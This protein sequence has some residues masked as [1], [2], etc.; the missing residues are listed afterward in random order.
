[1]LLRST[2]G[3]RVRHRATLR[4]FQDRVKVVAEGDGREGFDRRTEK[5][6]SDA[7]GH[8]GGR[9]GE[10]RR[11]GLLPAPAGGGPQVP[12]QDVRPR[13]PVGT[14]WGGGRLR[15]EERRMS[16]QSS[17]R[18]SAASSMQSANSGS[19]RSSFQIVA[20]TP[21]LSARGMPTAEYGRC[22]LSLR[23]VECG[24]VGLQVCAMAPLHEVAGRRARSLGLPA[25]GRPRRLPP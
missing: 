18:N 10:A 9:A 13:D 11:R 3:K 16:L 5:P 21:F 19:G 22:S 24:L 12:L 15:R 20:R 7:P 23:R 2:R 6:P 25:R 4:E 17:T 8:R 1:M 14:P